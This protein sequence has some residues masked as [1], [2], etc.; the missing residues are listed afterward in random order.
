MFEA[1]AQNNTCRF[2][3]HSQCSNNFINV[4]KQNRQTG[5]ERKPSKRD[6]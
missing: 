5:F 1:G 2:V 4:S 6:I 3:V